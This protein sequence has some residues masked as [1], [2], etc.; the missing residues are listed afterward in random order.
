MYHE[1]ELEAQERAGE[2]Q[3]GDRNGKAMSNQIIPGAMNFI[4]RQ[5][6]FI[7]SSQNKK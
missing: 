3:I 2:R 5:A 1:G 7:I 6:F 4:E